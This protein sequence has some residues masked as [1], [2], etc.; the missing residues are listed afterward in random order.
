VIKKNRVRSI[1]VD[2]QKLYSLSYNYWNFISAIEVFK[3]KI[4]YKYDKYKR[5]SRVTLN[6]R[7]HY[8]YEYTDKKYAF[9]SKA[10]KKEKLFSS[11]EYDKKSSR[12]KKYTQNSRNFDFQYEEIDKKR[13]TE[14]KSI[15]LTSKVSTFIYHESILGTPVVEMI[16][17]LFGANSTA[18]GVNK[19]PLR[20]NIYKEKYD[21][22][23]DKD[24]RLISRK[25][26]GINR[27]YSFDEYNRLKELKM[28]NRKVL[29]QYKDR[30]SNKIMGLNVDGRKYNVV[31]KEAE[32]LSVSFKEKSKTLIT[33][34]FDD[35]TTYPRYAKVHGEGV[36]EFFDY[37]KQVVKLKSLESNQSLLSQFNLLRENILFEEFMW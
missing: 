5:L 16:E 3:N 26:H 14:I 6:G 32:R 11:Y 36:I 28:A 27:N 2:G 37:E 4:S 1:L 19:L 25:G 13:T 35:L 21:Y 33:L 18:Y 12:V 10:Y 29:F 17:S 23:F 15:G 34:I 22:I 9:I 20:R 31:Y 30:F 8:R 7:P 24:S